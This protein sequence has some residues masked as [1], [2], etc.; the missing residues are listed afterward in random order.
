ML[1]YLARNLQRARILV[2]GTYRDA[3]V[4]RAV[5]GG[6]DRAAPRHQRGPYVVARAIHGR[7]SE[8][9][10]GDQPADDSTAICGTGAGSDRRQP[11]SRCV[12]AGFDEH[13]PVG[14]HQRDVVE[15]PSQLQTHCP[16]PTARV[17]G[18]SRQDPARQSEPSS[19]RPN[20]LAGRACSTE[21]ARYCVGSY[22]TP[23]CSHSRRPCS[24]LGTDTL[25]C[26][27][28]TPR[29]ATCRLTASDRRAGRTGRARL[30]VPA[31]FRCAR[32][33]LIERTRRLRRW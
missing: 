2:L 8:T 18:Q 17:D 19:D 6:T 15:Q 29:L 22:F 24:T 4:D 3:E 14:L 11:C 10:R 7:S 1:L 31:F 23:P 32:K 5:G 27:K 12:R 9:A 16:R 25:T 33:A 21:Q 13:I 28:S 30:V 20:S 26:P